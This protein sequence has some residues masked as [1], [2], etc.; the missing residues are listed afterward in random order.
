MVFVPTFPTMPTDDQNL[1]NSSD[2]ATPT[3]EPFVDPS[4]EQPATTEAQPLDTAPE[5]L[6]PSEVQWET[7]G[8]PL[9]CCLGVVVG[10]L[11][12][13]LLIMGVSI[14]LANGGFLSFATIPVL[15]AGAA[16]GGYLGWKIGKKLYRDY[17]QPVLKGRRKQPKPRPGV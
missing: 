6:L 13:F 2:E 4:V 16:L 9:G 10:L 5:P 15:L 3:E 11:L 8:G 17:D 14:L 7:N 12:T 1:E